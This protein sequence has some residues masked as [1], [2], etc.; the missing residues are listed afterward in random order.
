[1]ATRFDNGPLKHISNIVILVMCLLVVFGV[2]RSQVLASALKPVREVSSVA[3]GSHALYGWQA[4]PLIG[5]ATIKLPAGLEDESVDALLIPFSAKM[6][7]GFFK[8]GGLSLS[9]HNWQQVFTRKLL[10][11]QNSQI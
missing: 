4:G 7:I 9:S 3:S 1:M 10:A 2:P 8:T 5:I 11:T 6:K